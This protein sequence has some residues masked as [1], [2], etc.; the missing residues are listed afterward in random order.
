MGYMQ[1]AVRILTI[2]GLVLAVSAC[3]GV[4]SGVRPDRASKSATGANEPR[5]ANHDPYASNYG[6]ALSGDIAIINATS[7]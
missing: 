4:A 2:T 1:A 6:P 5:D 7:G 3:A